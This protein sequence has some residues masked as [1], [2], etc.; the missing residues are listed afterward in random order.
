VEGTSNKDTWVI[1]DLSEELDTYGNDSYGAYSMILIPPTNSTLNT[2]DDLNIGVECIAVNTT[3]SSN[4]ATDYAIEL[5]EQYTDGDSYALYWFADSMT[6]LESNLSDRISSVGLQYTFVST[7]NRIHL[8]L[9][10]EH[11][12]IKNTKD[13]FYDINIYSS[14]LAVSY[15]SYDSSEKIWNYSTDF[16]FSY[17]PT[18]GGFETVITT[19]RLKTF[20][21]VLSNTGGMFGPISSAVDLAALWLIFGFSIL[22]RTLCGY[23][24]MRRLDS[25]L[26][27]Q[28]QIYLE[29]I[30]IIECVYRSEGDVIIRPKI[31]LAI[32]NQRE[33]ANEAV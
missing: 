4:N 27:K 26:Q 30:G 6:K 23:A 24:S 33:T 22:G 9:F 7:V 14:L 18:G 5:I 19:S 15:T 17:N 1:I 21:D 32:Q 3:V 8:E 12:E 20:F 25:K 10:E 16:L 13:I 2:S 28:I 29:E 11:D 31:Q